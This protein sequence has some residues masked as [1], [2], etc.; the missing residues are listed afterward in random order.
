MLSYNKKKG[1]ILIIGFQDGWKRRNTKD[2]RL[3]FLHKTSCESTSYET[4]TPPSSS[5]LT[6]DLSPSIISVNKYYFIYIFIKRLIY[7]E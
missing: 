3:L 5:P 6:H 2:K 7:V 1:K 4:K